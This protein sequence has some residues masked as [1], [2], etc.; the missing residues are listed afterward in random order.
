ME[1]IH[2]ASWL[3]DDWTKEEMKEMGVKILNYP[4]VPLFVAAHAIREALR[5]IPTNI[6]LRG[7]EHPKRIDHS[8]FLELIGF[9]EITRLQEKYMPS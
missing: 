8:E 2:Y 5:G 3:N 1:G 9:P 4:L 7:L 6:T